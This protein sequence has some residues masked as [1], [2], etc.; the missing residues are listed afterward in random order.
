[1]VMMFTFLFMSSVVLANGQST[2]CW[3]SEHARSFIVDPEL[4]SMMNDPE[5][6]AVFGEMVLCFQM[7]LSHR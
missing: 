4:A 1:M 6:R 3:I 5:L 2:H 7:G